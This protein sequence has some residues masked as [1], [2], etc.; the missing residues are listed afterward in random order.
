MKTLVSMLT[1]V[2]TTTFGCDST[3]KSTVAVNDA[4]PT[5]AAPVAS[6]S[7]VDSVHVEDAVSHDVAAPVA[8]QTQVDA[9]KAAEVASGSGVPTKVSPVKDKK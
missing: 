5:V 4:T 1:F 6:A 2:V 9:A 3:V 8:V 7:A